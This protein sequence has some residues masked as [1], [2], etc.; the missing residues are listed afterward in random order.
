MTPRYSR[1]T[2]MGLLG[3]GAIA[4]GFAF[5]AGRP[6]TR[7]AVAL[8][9][10]SGTPESLPV[11]E[12]PLLRIEN[13]GG[14]VPVEYTLT[15]IPTFSM[16]AD[17]RVITTG[18]M[19]EIFPQPALPNLRVMTLNEKGIARVLGV[20][21]SAGLFDGSA[22]Y[23]LP[24]IADAQSTVFTLNAD[25]VSTEVSAY[26]LGFDDSIGMDIPNA[27]ARKKLNELRDFLFNLQTELTAEEITKADES[28]LSDEIRIFAAPIDPAS[29]PWQDVIEEPASIAWPLGVGLAE[30]GAPFTGPFSEGTRCTTI[31]GAD[32]ER[33]YKVLSGANQLT[34]WES[35][36]ELYQIWVRPLLPDESGCDSPEPATA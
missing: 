10:I 31:T 19:I 28:Y 30:I 13:T 21:K 1:R 33:L 35:E 22:D 7:S 11:A 17:G 20:A 23:E 34:P 5:S 25:G 24:N 2:F 16:F 6:L 27:E 9:F 29:P 36:G 3:G 12:K 14:F 4:T 8:T 26:A 15:A 32:V 18:P